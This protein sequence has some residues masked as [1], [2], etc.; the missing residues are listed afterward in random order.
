MSVPTMPALGGP[1]GDALSNAPAG[2]TQQLQQLAAPAADA[3]SKA[4]ALQ[5]QAEQARW[6]PR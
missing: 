2:A 6:R 4:A 5:S 1:L 3:A